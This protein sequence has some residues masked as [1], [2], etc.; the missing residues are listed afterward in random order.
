MTSLASAQGA[1]VSVEIESVN[2]L[3]V[4]D[5]P[6]GLL[7]MQSVLAAPG[8]LLVL[9]RSG[10]EALRS[11]LD[12]DF[13]VVLLDVRMPGFDGIETARMIRSRPRS[14][15]TPIIFLTGM[16]SDDAQMSLGY[17]VGAVDYVLKPFNPAILDS[18]VAV[19]VELYRTT[20][21]LLRQSVRTREAERRRDLAEAQNRI[22]ELS[23]SNTQLEQFAYA[24]SHDLREPLRMIGSYVQLLAERYAEHFDE[25]ADQWIGHA[26]DGVERMT[27]MIDGL[28][29]VA[30]VGG[31]E[32]T[33]EP[34]DMSA[35]FDS[36]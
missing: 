18:K 9:A 35:A 16:A 31:V 3:I 28:L 30:Q 24:A 11:M 13:A 32:G 25:T 36:A 29:E 4:D 33:L 26:V 14:A 22:L 20:R 7:A 12:Q 23:R 5:E 21:E 15:A 19:F 27:L 17:E 1:D 8:R 2:V 6:A 10:R 34:T